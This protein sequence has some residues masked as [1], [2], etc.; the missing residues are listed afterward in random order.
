MPKQTS[1]QKLLPL[2]VMLIGW[3]VLSGHAPKRKHQYS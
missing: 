1:F 3:M 2:V